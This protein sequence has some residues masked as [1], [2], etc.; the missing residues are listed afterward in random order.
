[1]LVEWLYPFAASLICLV[2]NIQLLNQSSMLSRKKEYPS[3]LTIV[4]WQ[5]DVVQP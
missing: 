2:G 3:S 1:M 4:R 5:T